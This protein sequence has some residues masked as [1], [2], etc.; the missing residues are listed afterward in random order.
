[1][2]IKLSA[3]LLAVAAMVTSGGILADVG[4]DHGYV[5]ICLAAQ[6]KISGAIAM[7]INE[8]PLS[9]AQAHIDENGMSAQIETRI[10]DG[11]AA[12]MPGEADSILIAGM[13]GMLM[14]RILSDGE[15]VCRTVKELILQPQSDI[16]AV[17]GHLRTH[18]FTVV[19]EDM[20]FEDGKYY[21]MMRALPAPAGELSPVIDAQADSQTPRDA[22]TLAAADRYGPILLR[23][24]H[25]VLRDYL[26]HE[27]SRLTRILNRL[28]AQLSSDDIERRIAE[29]QRELEIIAAAEKIVSEEN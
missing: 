25:P 2:N 1:M 22:L 27:R 5:P 28:S 16:A 18:G 12:L 10:S 3:R 26:A 19:D 11:L 6:G 8:G 24:A 7:D 23:N 9:R 14:K 21:Q 15:Q 13:G 29:V 17:R 20:V 4:T